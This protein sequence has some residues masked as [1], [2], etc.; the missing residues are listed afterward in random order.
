MPLC[1]NLFLQ[2]KEMQVNF[3][4]QPKHIVGLDEFAQKQL[5]RL[6]RYSDKIERADIFYKTSKNPTS[7]HIVEIKLAIPGPDAF[8]SE[9][10]DS[11][12]KAF[13]LCVTKLEQQLKKRVNYHHN[14]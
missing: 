7:P 1:V 3:N 5:D 6:E 11:Y 9:Q 4:S 14:T 12:G 13:N 2:K 10:A 8:A